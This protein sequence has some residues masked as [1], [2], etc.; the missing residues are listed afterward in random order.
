MKNL[1]KCLTLLVAVLALQGCIF[2][3]S[4]PSNNSANNSTNSPYNNDSGILNGF[5][6]R[7]FSIGNGK[8]AVFARGNLQYNPSTRRWRCAQHQ[9]EYIGS[10][11]ASSSGWIDMFGYGTSGYQN[12]APYMKSTNNA[13]YYPGDIANSPYSWGKNNRIENL[14]SDYN[15]TVLSLDEWTYLLKYR[16]DASQL[17]SI[18]KVNGV[19]GLILLPDGFQQIA[20]IPVVPQAQDLNTN[21]YSIS[22]WYQLQNSGAVFLPNAGFR[23]GT[24]VKE[25]GVKGHYW[26][27]TYIGNGKAAGIDVSSSVYISTSCNLFDGRTVRLVSI[28]FG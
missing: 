25:V 19:P 2:L 6:N 26:L 20:N 4:A 27:G 13:D 3:Q 23:I 9:W 21:N 11:N 14:A 17:Y 15:P 28:S 7:T 5:G 12:K 1:F 8:S 16:K 18:G 22:Q 10:A 24:D